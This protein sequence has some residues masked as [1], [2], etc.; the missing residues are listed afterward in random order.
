MKKI[1][2]GLVLISYSFCFAQYYNL[3][4]K[5]YNPYELF[6]GSHIQFINDSVGWIMPNR[7]RGGVYM[8]PENNALFKTVNG[9]KSWFCVYELESGWID[10]ADQMPFIFTDADTG[11]YFSTL[12]D[13]WEWKIWKTIDG[14]NN[15]NNVYTFPIQSFF[16]N[17]LFINGKVGWISDFDDLYKTT[18]GGFSWNVVLNF[19]NFGYKSYP[20][21]FNENEGF[22]ITS[23][24]SLSVLYKTIN[25]QTWDSV[26]VLNGYVKS[27]SFINSDIGYIAIDGNLSKTVNGGAN[28]TNI[29]LPIGGSPV[30]LVEALND[31]VVVA[32]GY[33]YDLQSLTSFYISTDAGSTWILNS[34]TGTYDYRIKM[35][36]ILDQDN[37]FLAC[38]H[39]VFKVTEMGTHW[40]KLAIGPTYNLE[41]IIEIPGGEVFAVG[42]KQDSLTLNY[43]SSIINSHPLWRTK[44]THQNQK[45]KCITAKNNSE[46]F[47][48]GYDYLNGGRSVIFKCDNKGDNLELKYN[49]AGQI[50]NSMQFITELN[51]IAVGDEGLLLKTQDGGNN[52]LQE[53]VTTTEDLNFVKFSSQLGFIGGSNGLLLRTSDGGI[54]WSQ[55]SIGTNKDIM[56]ILIHTQN[57]IW[58]VGKDGLI[59]KSED[60]GLNWVTISASSDYDLNSIASKSNLHIGIY[61]GKKVDGTPFIMESHVSGNSW[62]FEN[63]SS[64]LRSINFVYPSGNSAWAVGDYGTILNS[65]IWFTPVELTTFTATLNRTK[66]NINWQT[67]TELNNQGF[68]IQRKFENSDWFTIGFRTGKGTTTE[69]TSYFYEDDI[70]EI[71]SDKLY[72]RLKQIDFNGTFSFSNEVE[73]IT[74]P[75]D[76][77]LYQNYPNPFN[78]ITT[79]KY[80]VPKTSNVKLEIFDVL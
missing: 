77:A 37:I 48:G 68:E 1:T 54:N 36:S 64:N 32:V 43:E 56:S 70:W 73:V 51:G 75:L 41:N 27:A 22:F 14:G 21:F 24:T 65:A 39:Y 61:G 52:W 31:S 38:H 72:Y 55:I 58:L 69:P 71:N 44:S 29:S 59:M 18:D 66:V 4:W 9:G 17:S 13:T 5:D 76:F 26:T 63:T 62:V 15:W 7:D 74:Q 40:E 19:S 16:L 25:G 78:P 11:Y 42:W 60:A 50:V 23:N 2:L 34:S 10:Y 28:W 30:D 47:I 80:Q 33:S 35:M 3:H 46:L 12:Y 45:L 57:N 67:A 49:S 20:I 53:T 6:Y 79:I 8:F